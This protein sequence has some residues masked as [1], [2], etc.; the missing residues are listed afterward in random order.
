MAELYH[1]YQRAARVV[2][3]QRRYRP[4][5]RGSSLLSSPKKPFQIL[6]RH[7]VLF[8]GLLNILTILLNS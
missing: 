3:V 7:R 4:T 1:R 8:A 2:G 6:A 5:D